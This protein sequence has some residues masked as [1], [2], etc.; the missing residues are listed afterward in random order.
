MTFTIDF[1]VLPQVFSHLKD[2]FL[3]GRIGMALFGVFNN[4]ELILSLI[5]GVFIFKIAFYKGWHRK[6]ALCSSFILVGI[7][8]LYKFYLTPRI[9]NATNILESIPQDDFTHR[10]EAFLVHQGYHH[11]YIRVDSIKILILLLLLVLMLFPKENK[12]KAST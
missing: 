11:W 9:I 8:T 2:I 6:I 4:L 5:I 12:E 1:M 3:G 10:G 7:A